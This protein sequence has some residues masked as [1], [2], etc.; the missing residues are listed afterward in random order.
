M[1]ETKQIQKSGQYWL[2]PD[3]NGFLHTVHENPDLFADYTD[4]T[5]EQYP[6]WQDL[7]IDPAL[8]DV[9]YFWDD[10][11]SWKSSDDFLQW[12]EQI[13]DWDFDNKQWIP[14]YAQSDGPRDEATA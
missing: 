3:D 5:W 1:I 14:K 2:L 10:V 11:D 8:A 6:D 13:A 12:I 4:K 7:H 9:D